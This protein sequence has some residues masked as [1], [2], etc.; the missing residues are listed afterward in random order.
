MHNQ[1]ASA[2]DAANAQSLQLPLKTLGELS[3]QDRDLQNRYNNITAPFDPRIEAARGLDGTIDEI[4]VEDLSGIPDK[5]RDE[6]VTC[7][8]C[9]GKGHASEI[10]PSLKCTACN[11]LDDHFS[12]ACPRITRCPKCRERGHS[13]DQCPSKL[14]RSAAA[15]GVQC[16]LCN[17]FGH[18]EQACSLI[19]RFYNPAAIVPL[20]K[21][22]SMTIG[23]YYCGSDGHYGVDC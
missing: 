19:W 14:I 15:D 3:V 18:T 4:D 10:C 2:G 7:L 16:D 17:Q 8:V 6:P 1:Q 9:A 12:S 23:C 5:D 21:V 11:A 22:P 20:R 13:K